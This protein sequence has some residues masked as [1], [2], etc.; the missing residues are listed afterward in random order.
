MFQPNERADLPK[1]DLEA[2]R[3]MR[4]LF[5]GNASEET[6]TKARAFLLGLTGFYNHEISERHPEAV[7]E[8]RRIMAT[9]IE[10]TR[11]S[12]PELDATELQSEGLS[13]DS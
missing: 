12:V 11:L 13:Q 2:R 3:V 10:Y 7:L 5:E 9:I 6:R 8:A 4:L 1:D